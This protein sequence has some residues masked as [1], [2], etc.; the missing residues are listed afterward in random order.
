[1]SEQEI[2]TCYNHPNRET[3]LRCNR[4]DQPIC[5]QCAI[6]TPTGYRCKQC[7]KTQQKVF[8]TVKW[9]DYPIAIIV[10]GLLSSLGCLIMMTV[11]Q[12]CLIIPFVIGPSIGFGI[13]EGVRL[14][15][16]RRRSEWLF[17]V[18]A[19]AGGL[20]VL[21][22]VI[23]TI[24]STVQAFSVS[25]EQSAQSGYALFALTPLLY[26]AIYLITVVPSIYYRMKGIRLK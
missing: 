22:Y 25:A 23:I 19:I 2:I 9:F 11:G 13:A 12:M 18:T 1:M 16:R 20:A 3:V 6:K 17:R 8:V 15:V 7:V 14:L 24:I 21:P 5:V 10:A 4:C 26:V